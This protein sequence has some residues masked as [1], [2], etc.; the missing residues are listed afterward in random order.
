MHVANIPFGPVPIKVDI[1]DGAV[2]YSQ[3]Q[4]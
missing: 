1:P 4:S 2:G 3:Q